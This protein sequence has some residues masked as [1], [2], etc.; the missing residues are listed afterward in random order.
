MENLSLPDY[1]TEL[2]FQIARDD[3]LDSPSIKISAGSGH[4]DGYI[5]VLSRVILT[6]IQNGFPKKL[7]LICKMAPE[8]KDRRA[9]FNTVAI[10]ER[11]VFVYRTIL[12]SFVDFQRDKGIDKYNG[13]FAFPKIYA[14]VC[15]V[16]KDHFV[17]IMDD[18]V[19]QGFQ[20][21]N[22]FMPMNLEHVK[23]FV[24]ELGRFH[25]ISFALRDQIPAMFDDFLS[26]EDTLIKHCQTRPDLLELMFEQSFEQVIECLDPNIDGEEIQKVQQLQQNYFKQLNECVERNS[27]GKYGVFNHGDCWGN[28]LMFAYD[29]MV[30]NACNG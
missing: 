8:N 25:A 12:S 14:A 27:A 10:F 17:I 6:G 20:L 29:E 28:N 2:L 16:Q 1:V 18:L 21:W 15:D 30:C 23:V 19:E 11:E 24:A 22:R 7:S 3:N 13:F 5:G 9:E 26:M 4:C